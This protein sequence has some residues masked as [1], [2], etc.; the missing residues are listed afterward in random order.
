MKIM[1][2]AHALDTL[3]LSG[4]RVVDGHFACAVVTESPGAEIARGFVLSLWSRAGVT[5]VMKETAQ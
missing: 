4:G 3:C 2:R 5:P 1:F